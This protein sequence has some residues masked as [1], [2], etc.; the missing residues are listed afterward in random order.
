MTAAR[1]KLKNRN[2]LPRMKTF[3]PKGSQVSR[4]WRLLDANGQTLG[5]LATQAAIYL[6]GKHKPTY[7]PH[8]DMGDHV[9]IVNA[10]R[11][12]VT[13]QKL[14]QKVYYRHSGYT[15]GLKS[16]TLEQQLAKFPGRVIERAVRGML[17][18]TALGNAMYRK[19]H[20]YAG[21]THPHRGQA[22]AGDSPV[23][24]EKSEKRHR[25]KAPE[26]ARSENNQSRERK[27][28]SGAGRKAAE[29]HPN[30]NNKEQTT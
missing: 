19:L 11:I 13:G 4:Q 23:L 18:R 8:M 3:S 10:E 6:R 12:R 14:K 16:R 7:A 1:S 2:W 29:D 28:A 24:P 21:P 26:D 30:E 9:I 5:R 20:V 27:R 17:P 22:L 15:G 25:E